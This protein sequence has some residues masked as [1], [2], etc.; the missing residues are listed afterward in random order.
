MIVILKAEGLVGTGH[1]NVITYHILRRQS[2]MNAEAPMRKTPPIT[3]SRPVSR[4]RG[5]VTASAAALLLAGTPVLAEPP[6]VVTD[7]TPV[8]SLVSQV[9]AGVAEPILLVPPG[10]SPH[11][12]ALR[13]SQAR[14]LSEADIVIWAGEANTVWL[15][16]A[17][18][19]LAPDARSL[20][21]IEVEGTVLRKLDG[22][23]DHAEDE[24][25][26]HAEDH[27]D[28]DHED[29]HEDHASG[30]HDNGDHAAHDDHDHD[31][32]GHDGHD[33][34]PGSVDPHVWLDPENARV[35]LPVIADTLAQ[36]DPDNAGT[37]RTNADQ[38]AAELDTLIAHVRETL[39]G[40]QG[41]FV[42]F[43]DAYGYFLDRFGMAHGESLSP[44]DATDPGPARL[45]ALRDEIADEGIECLFTEPQFNP[46]RAQTLA[47]DLDLRQGV[48][49]PLGVDLT[50][51]PTLYPQLIQGI[52]DSLAVCLK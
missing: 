32:D 36:A 3:P 14:T 17:L 37:Y 18:A 34:A 48:L 22:G 52:A 21:M 35:W 5:L 33:H 40:A 20:P 39:D 8:H 43:H 7:I 12:F 46:R 10:D 4:T 13:P 15:A 47:N 45:A 44:S 26:D 29:H 49:D 42:T 28:A 23:H 41:G 51:G 6:S 19:T 25:G 30:D 27:E 1:C 16:E 31:H 50:P 9:M 38:A 24:G 11:G 2:Q